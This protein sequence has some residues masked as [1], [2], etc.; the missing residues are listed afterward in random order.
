[1][2]DTPLILVFNCGSSSVKGAVLDSADGRRLL[3]CLAEKL[4]SAEASMHFTTAAGKHSASLAAGHDHAAAAA[5]LMD[6]LARLGL[7]ARIAAI[8]HRVVHGGERFTAS[9]LIDEAV[10]ADIEACIA[11]APLHNPAH[12]AGIRAAQAAFPQLPQV[13]V[14]DTAF[15]QT[16]PDY[17]YRYAVPE[18]LYSRYGVRRYGFHGTSYRY[19]AAQSARLLGCDPADLGLVIAHLGNGA[20]VCA[21]RNGV[22]Q[23]TSMGLTPLEGLV[24]G[25]RSGDVDPALFAFLH[26][27]ADMD[28][29]AVNRM[30]NQE[31]GLL[32]LSCLSNDCRTLEAAAEEGHAGAQRALA[33]FAYRLA[34]YVAAMT[35]AAGRLDALVFTGGIGENSA[36]VR[37]QVL[38]H[39][40][41]LGLAVDAAANRAACR[42]ASGVISP[43][44]CTPLAL[45]VPTDEE[46]MI[47]RDTALVSGIQAA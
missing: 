40:Q 4:G 36:R 30:L 38:G 24:M 22:S 13:A 44:G 9:T 23:D 39:L 43:P 1:M 45:V 42:G 21:V 29:A 35:V 15:H 37:A 8:G 46:A 10:M 47:A 3:S 33:V 31:S 17:A 18:T 20:S 27:N 6:E 34:K 2:H 25:T 41:V 32:G 11:L 26:D 14:F 5:A 28:L 12:I 16:L 19:V 7:L